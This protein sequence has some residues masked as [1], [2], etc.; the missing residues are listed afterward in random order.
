MNDETKY[1]VQRAVA[2]RT[3]DST[4][5]ADQRLIHPLLSHPIELEGQATRHTQELTDDSFFQ[6]GE[7][8]RCVMT[9]TDREHLIGNIVTHLCNTQE[10][11][12]LRQTALFYKSDLG[13]GRR[14]AK[15]L[16]LDVKKV[17]KLAA[18]SQ[19]NCVKATSA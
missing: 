3:T 15:A 5:W 17:E 11:I 4:L 12:Q 9:D 13:Y 10:R 6:A 19:E 14:V 16:G 2:G 1:L 18:M 7:L 8:Y